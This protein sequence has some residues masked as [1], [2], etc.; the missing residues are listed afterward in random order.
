MLAG[1]F[2][3]ADL[4]VADSVG[5]VVDVDALDVGFAFLEV[6][7][8]DVVLLTAVKVDGFF[9]DERERAGEIDFA[10]DIWR[11]GDVDDHEIVACYGAQADGIGGT[12]PLRPA[13][14]FTNQLQ[15]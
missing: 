1:D 7:M 10:N 12:G 6:E 15:Q 9:V 3:D 13:V 5:V 14:S 11:A 8:F 2:E 4:G